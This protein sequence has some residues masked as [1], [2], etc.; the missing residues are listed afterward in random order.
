I[1]MF[2]EVLEIDPDDPLATFGMGK[3]YVQ[4]DDYESAIPHLKR[5]TEIQKDYSAAWLDY[6]KCLEFTG[7]TD[8]AVAAYR[9]GIQAAS[10]KGDLMPM[11]EMERR[12]KLL[13]G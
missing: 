1:G 4:L 8:E 12:L 10:R 6:G 7:R 2:E 5:A 3:A 13:E 9:Q 11:R